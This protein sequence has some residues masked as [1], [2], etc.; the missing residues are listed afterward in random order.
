MYSMSL[1]YV[2]IRDF[3]LLQE[4]P[5]LYNPLV[6]EHCNT[7]IQKELFRNLYPINPKQKEVKKWQKNVIDDFIIVLI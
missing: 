6:T 5:F 3:T 1:S 2:P 7:E 4:S